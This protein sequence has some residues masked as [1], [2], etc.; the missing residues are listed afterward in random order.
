VT[1]GRRVKIE[2]SAL[3]EHAPRRAPNHAQQRGPEP[4]GAPGCATISTLPGRTHRAT[5]LAI[6]DHRPLVASPAG[7]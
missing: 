3:F 5:A 6:H 7:S 4:A 2:Q 1:E